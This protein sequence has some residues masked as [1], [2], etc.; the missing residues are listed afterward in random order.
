MKRRAVMVAG[1]GAAVLTPL[2]G[3]SGCGRSAVGPAYGGGWVGADQRRGHLLRDRGLPGPAATTR[4][5]AVVIVGG[6]V[7]GLACARALQRRGVDDVHLLELEDEAG[8][9]ARGHTMASMACP[10]GAHYLPVPDPANHDLVE[11]LAELGLC[12]QQG[13]RWI[14]DERHLCHSPQE[15]LFMPDRAS[16]LGGNW[17]EGLLPPLAG[18]PKA[19][20]AATELA[21]RRFGSAIDREMKQRSF[22]I[23]TGQTDWNLRL[24][25]L[26]A[27]TFGDW[28]DHEGLN[29]PALRWYL[30]Y[31]C[32]DD[33]GAESAQVSAW[34]GLHYFASR[35]GFERFG[36]E[37]NEPA[38]NGVLTWA[39][40]NAWLT[41]KL[42][43]PI[44][45][46]LHRARTVLRIDES[47]HAVNVDA[48]DHRTGQ[49]ERWTARQVVL[50]T[51]LFIAAR[52]ASAPSAA[53]Q[54]AAAALSYAPWLVANLQ[55]D[56]AL[57][58]WPGAPPSWD[59]V[60]YGSASLGYVD[61]M[62]Q[63]TRPYAG[64]TVLT[65][66]WAL[67]GNNAAQS[68]EARKQLLDLPWQNW[69]ERVLAELQPAHADLRS[70]VRR[71]DLMRYGH[72]MCVPRPG[73]RGLAALQALR[74]QAGRISFAHSDLSAYSI[75]EEAFFHGHHV[76]SALQV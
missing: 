75:F 26:D 14:Y 44:G 69:A 53:L 52:L 38:S 59:N 24:Q 67:G 21:Y 27:Q 6:G 31:C 64:P 57:H 3:L 30:D 76:G 56:D 63:S 37:R 49:L 72:A 15:R 45:D 73:I 61:A 34:A 51:P 16:A 36:V 2:A 28:L 20:R 65:S 70:K 25:A 1:A 42:A 54:A 71:I 5:A 10:L 68:R 32:R 13:G 19:Q 41:R 33:Y 7:A 46:R 29:A 60:L 58:D 66:Y 35:H 55:L 18:L 12:Q 8:G 74:T 39:E 4:Q 11:W 40:G 47:I 48:F 17:I 50:A 22:A 62:H 43:Q 23:P 9:N